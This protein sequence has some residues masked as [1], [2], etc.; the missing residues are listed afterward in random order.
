M[1]KFIEVHQQGKLRLI[2]LAWVE[3]IWPAEDGTQ[4]FHAFTNPCATSQDCTVADESY[5][6]IRE[7]VAHA[8]G[9]IAAGRADNG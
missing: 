7:L 9:V 1:A 6:E 2:N 5:E 3:D 8:Q 4:I